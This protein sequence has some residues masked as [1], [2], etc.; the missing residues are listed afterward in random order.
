MLCEA[1]VAKNWVP[2][3]KDASTDVHWMRWQLRAGWVAG[4]Q[5]RFAP[6]RA[7]CTKT[8]QVDGCESCLLRCLFGGLKGDPITMTKHDFWI[9]HLTRAEACRAGRMA[10][11]AS[12]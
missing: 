9:P 10:G 5:I 11:L 4:V 6:P 2:V 1:P 12:P 3:S 7:F 8:S